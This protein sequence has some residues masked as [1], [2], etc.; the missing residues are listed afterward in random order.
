MKLSKNGYIMYEIEKKDIVD[1][2]LTF[3]ETVTY[4]SSNFK[5]NTNG[6][7]IEKLVL[8]NVKVIS[9][10][11]FSGLPVKEIEALNLIKIGREAFKDCSDLEIVKCPQLEI[12][13]ERAFQG[14]FK[15]KHVDL[16]QIKEIANKA[17]EYIDS[18]QIFG[19]LTY[20]KIGFTAEQSNS[21]ILQLARQLREEKAEKTKK[22]SNNTGAKYSRKVI[23]SNPNYTPDNN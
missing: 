19:F 16:V 22:T 6:K 4:I 20:S 23:I 11:V 13:E 12:I 2:V 5:F 9:S 7:K 14:C 3:P 18:L 8:S 10:K 17:F 21:L 15:L 1:G